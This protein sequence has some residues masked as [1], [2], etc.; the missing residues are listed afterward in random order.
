MDLGSIGMTGCWLY[1]SIDVSVPLVIPGD[2][3][4]RFS[5]SI[6]NRP[7]LV[8]SALMSARGACDDQSNRRAFGE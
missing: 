8:T 5:L 4:G 7:R 1:Q 2:G 6:P 3:T